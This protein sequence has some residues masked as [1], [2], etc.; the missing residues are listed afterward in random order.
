MLACWGMLFGDDIQGC[1]TERGRCENNHKPEEAE[2]S[3]QLL[4]STWSIISN[5]VCAS[6]YLAKCENS[7]L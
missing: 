4:R 1:C 5:G 2:Y 7:F 6:W 3:A